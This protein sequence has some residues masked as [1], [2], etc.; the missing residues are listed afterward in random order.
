MKTKLISATLGALLLA[1][2]PFALA[3]RDDER[4]WQRGG[5]DRGADVRGFRV[6]REGFADVHRG[7]DRGHGWKHG[8]DRGH[9]WKHGHNRHHWKRHHYGHHPHWHGHG[10]KHWKERHYRHHYYSDYGYAPRYYDRDGV[11]IIFR[12]TFH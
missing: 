2:S 9:G 8:H 11:T 7:H 4:R 1:G 12:G 6:P 3:E 10:K 5:H